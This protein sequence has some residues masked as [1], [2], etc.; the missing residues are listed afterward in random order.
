MV[1]HLIMI[2]KKKQIKE[3]QEKTQQIR[4]GGCTERRL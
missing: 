1:A 2:Y 4:A 3:N